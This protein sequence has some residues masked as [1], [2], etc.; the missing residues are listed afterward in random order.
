MNR[1]LVV[2]VMKGWLFLCSVALT[3]SKT[4]RVLM[5]E[6]APDLLMHPPISTPRIDVVDNED[7]QATAHHDPTFAVMSRL[8]N[9]ELPFL[10]SFVKHYRSLGATAFYFLNNQFQQHDE[11]LGFLRAYDFKGI[12]V[13]LKSYQHA[14]VE[15]PTPSTVVKDS[16]LL[17]MFRET[18]VVSVDIDEYWLLPGNMSLVSYVAAFPGDC[19]FMHWLQVPSDAL[20]EWP[21][22][23]Y[24]GH[25]GHRGKWM[26]RVA[27]ILDMRLSE[28][29]LTQPSIVVGDS[30]KHHP[31][32]VGTLIH[33][34]GRNFKDVATKAYSQTGVLKSKGYDETSN[35]VSNGRIPERL[36]ILAFLMIQRELTSNRESCKPPDCWVVESAIDLLQVDA[37]LQS[38]LSAQALRVPEPSVDA[39]V[40]HLREIYVH[41]KAYLR[42]LRDS[43]VRPV[44]YPEEKTLN[45]V[46]Q[47]LQEHEPSPETLKSIAASSVA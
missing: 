26:A 31:D 1:L 46:G 15:F 22:P 23:P 10:A 11:I 28:P 34:W 27:N 14:E 3:S 2:L 20:F 8:Y 4:G 19:Y 7:R 17:S 30:Y 16:L 40:A 44:G 18:F 5:A 9:G 36:Q 45:D 35:D 13:T 41:Y 6:H 38:R 32:L 33:F 43:G 39:E 21:R 24:I 47:W 25:I 37:N 42:G 12:R 29:A